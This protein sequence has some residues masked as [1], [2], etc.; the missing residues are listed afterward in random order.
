MIYVFNRNWVDTRWQQYIIARQRPA[1]LANH[2]CAEYFNIVYVLL[3]INL[4]YTK[5][6]YF[7]LARRL[8]QQHRQ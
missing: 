4:P 7:V 5:Y 3:V 6:H 8:V 2:I 1:Q